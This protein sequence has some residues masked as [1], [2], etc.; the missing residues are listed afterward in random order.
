MYTVQMLSIER[1][2][3][4][5]FLEQDGVFFTGTSLEAA[6]NIPRGDILHA[7]DQKLWS[8]WRKENYL[9]FQRWLSEHNGGI[10]L[11]LGAGPQQFRDLT[12]S[13]FTVCA[14][15]AVADP[16]I[17]VV[18]D[19]NEKLPFKSDTFDVVFLS[20]VLE[21][22]HNPSGLSSEIY[23][24]AKKG[25]FIIGTVPFLMQSHQRP[26]DY[27]R[28]TDICLRRLLSEVG[29]HE[30]VVIPLG[31]PLNVIISMQHK[32]FGTI[33]QSIKNRIF[34]RIFRR[35]VKILVWSYK[36]AFG[37]IAPNESF[38]EGY[39]FSAYKP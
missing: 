10:L 8:N 6:H 14:V 19:I 32:F 3:E 29:F 30:V 37:P 35:L 21:H 26:H 38:T 17:N 12:H 15:D 22:V 7:Q 20:N 24:V 27:Y 31:S 34:K 25:G 4:T 1:M 5:P 18:C 2:L 11:D 16:G 36:R 39:G 9:F 23:R 33:P 13:K 28:Y